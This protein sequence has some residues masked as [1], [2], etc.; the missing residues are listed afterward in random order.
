MLRLDETFRNPAKEMMAQGKKM[1]GA[2]LQ[3][4]SPFAAEIFAKAGLD[5]LVVDLEHGPG[6]IRD[7]I[8]QLHAMG[9]FD[10]IPFARTPWNDM[11][12]MKRILDAGVYGVIVPYINTAEE[13]QAAVSY[14]KYPLAGVR[15]VAPSPRAAG[16]GMNSQNYLQH[17]ND[18]IAVVAAIETGTAVGNLDEIL[19]VDGLDGIFIGPTDLSSSLG[20]FGQ[21]SHAAVREVI[22]L[23]EE[24]T[25]ASGKCLATIAGSFEQAQALFERGYGIVM[26]MSDS[27]TLARIAMETVEQFRRAF[28]ER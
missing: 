22:A 9:R 13:A 24:H 6:D 16:Y 1:L 20:Y 2:W 17:A 7:L 3:T 4:A 10:A 15:G 8:S 18:E 12:M 11:V 19:S 26:A 28:P 5:I 25:L 21:P 27:S 14:C 23:I